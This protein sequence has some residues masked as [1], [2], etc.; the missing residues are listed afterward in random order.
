MSGVVCFFDTAAGP[1]AMVLVGAMIVAS[2]ETTWAGLVAPA[3]FRRAQGHLRTR[4]GRHQG[5]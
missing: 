2:V 4:Q 5:R 1:L 3:A